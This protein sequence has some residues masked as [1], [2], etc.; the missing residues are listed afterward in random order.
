MG[1]FRSTLLPKIVEIIFNHIIL[2]H[3]I[4]DFFPITSVMVMFFPEAISLRLTA[5]WVI[6]KYCMPAALPQAKLW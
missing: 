2:S 1:C 3:K 6:G 4:L 5:F